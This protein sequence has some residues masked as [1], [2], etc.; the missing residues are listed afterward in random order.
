VAAHHGGD[1]GVEQRRRHRGHTQV[2]DLEVLAGRME[3]LE[4]LGLAISSS[5]GTSRCLPRAHR[6]PR[7][8]RV[9]R[10]GPG[11]AWPVG[12]FPHELGIDRDEFGV[13]EGLADAANAS[14]VV[15]SFIGCVL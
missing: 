8:R 10:P 13:G 15:M 1:L 11:R 2:E 14:V 5:S 3:D 7:R 6:S 9:R 4:D 12:A